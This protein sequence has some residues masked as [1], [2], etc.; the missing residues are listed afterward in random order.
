MQLVEKTPIEIVELLKKQGILTAKGQVLINLMGVSAEMK[1]NSAIGYV[2]Q[3]WFACWLKENN[4]FF[5]EN[6][7]SQEFPD[8]YLDADSNKNKL[9]EVKTFDFDAGANFDVANFDAYCRSLKT[10]AYRLDADYL[11]FG[12]T[13]KSGVLEIKDIWLKKIWEITCASKKFPIKT[14]NKQDVIYN[15]RPAVWFSDKATYP[16]FGTEKNF[17]KG[18][19]ETLKKYKSE[20]FA[21]EWITEV[22]ANNVRYKGK[23]LNL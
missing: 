2:F 5:R 14:Q 12:Y 19:F 15:I 18:L 4:I 13:F 16:V 23:G 9:L 7:N 17:M 20:E 10:K 1:E 11:I 8:F 6:T 21:R 3:E 22:E